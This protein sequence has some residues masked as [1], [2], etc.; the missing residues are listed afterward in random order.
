MG[1][2]VE[3]KAFGFWLEGMFR[4]GNDIRLPVIGRYEESQKVLFMF[5]FIIFDT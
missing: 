4:L 3:N 2:Y 5:I 1:I